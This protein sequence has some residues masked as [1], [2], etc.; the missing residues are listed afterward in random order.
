MPIGLQ[1]SLTFQPS[2]IRKT[3]LKI[4]NS[5]FEV[6][7][8]LENCHENGEYPWSPLARS[9]PLSRAA[10]GM[11]EIRKAMPDGGSEVAGIEGVYDALVES[12]RIVGGFTRFRFSEDG[13]LAQSPNVVVEGTKPPATA[14]SPLAF[15][16]PLCREA[17]TRHTNQACKP[18]SELNTRITATERTQ[19]RRLQCCGHLHSPAAGVQPF[20]PLSADLVGRGRS[21]YHNL[22]TA[23]EAVLVSRIS[24]IGQPCA[25]SLL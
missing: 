19:S 18:D 23:A 22:D 3:E 6:L 13:G 2:K 1:N 17:G 12:E 7:V 15:Q 5:I 20:I 25:P 8:K 11:C 9:T 4:G 24:G 16:N 14:S 21:P 10:F